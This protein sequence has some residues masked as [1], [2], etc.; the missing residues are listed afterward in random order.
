MGGLD[1]YLPFFF[2]LSY[3]P[4]HHTHTPITVSF[5]LTLFNNILG[6]P[7]PDHLHTKFF[8]NPT[9]VGADCQILS[10]RFAPCA[11]DLR[12]RR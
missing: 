6:P 2:P 7:A 5:S 12:G 1:V 9:V 3:Y 4:P 11:T 10:T 8:F